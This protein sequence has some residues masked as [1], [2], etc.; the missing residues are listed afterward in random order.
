MIVQNVS[1]QGHTDISFTVGQADLQKTM[2]VLKDVCQ[3]VK[4]EKV[5]SDEQIAKFSVVGIGMKSHAGVAASLFETLAHEGI[6]IEMISTS[7]IKISCV[8]RKANA[9]KAVQAVHKK[10]GL[11]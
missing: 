5:D 4:A 7:E 10:F 6:N 11:G 8:I 3:E 1:E 9:D 2:K